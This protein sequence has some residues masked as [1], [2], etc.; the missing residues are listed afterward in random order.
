MLLVQSACAGRGGTVVTTALPATIAKAMAARRSNVL[1]MLP[2]SS[3]VV[4]VACVSWLRVTSHHSHAAYGACE[5]REG[6]RSEHQKVF[7]GR[8]PPFGNA[9]FPLGPPSH[10]PG[11][12]YVTGI[13]LHRFCA[14]Q[15]CPCAQPM[16]LSHQTTYLRPYL[17]AC[18]GLTSALSVPDRQSAEC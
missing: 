12:R 2:R 10:R 4:V 6:D 18:G 9:Y 14:Y 1:T 8:I 15:P 3:A 16:A 11:K 13:T 17:D 5:E 7:H